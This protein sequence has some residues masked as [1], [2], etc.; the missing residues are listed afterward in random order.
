[1]PGRPRR[2]RRRLDEVV[3]Q[4]RAQPG[5]RA[6]GIGRLT[7]VGDPRL[8][9]DAG[10]VAFTVTT[11]DLDAN[12]YRSSIW[13]A[14]VDGS[15]APRA[16][17]SGEHKDSAPRWSP[18]GRSIAFVRHEQDSKDTE[19]CVIPAGGGE[20]RVL[21]TWKDEVSDLAWSPDGTRL[22]FLGRDRDE[23]RYGKDKEKDQ[24]PRRITR[25]WSRFDSVGW[26]ADRPTHLFVVDIDGGDPVAVTS[27]EYEDGGLAW[28]P[29]GRTLAFAAGRHDTFD[30]DYGVDL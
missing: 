8:S 24:P 18:D 22:A 20:A 16:F 23:E 27:G 21:L 19:V 12:E 15:E 11:I 2:R 29:D 30:L 13:L 4:S 3:P 17:T 25:L 9:P 10:T 14:A 1:R 5:M 28:S 6:A 7:A 26:I